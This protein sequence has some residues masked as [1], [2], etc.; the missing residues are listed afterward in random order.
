MLWYF[1]FLAISAAVIFL[2][3]LVWFLCPI[4]HLLDNFRHQKIMS[5]VQFIRI[6]WN[7][8]NSKSF[9][10]KVWPHHYTAHFNYCVLFVPPFHILTMK[11]K[12]NFPNI[13]CILG[14]EIYNIFVL[15][16]YFVCH[17]YK[18]IIFI[19]SRSRFFCTVKTLNLNF[20][21]RKSGK[22]TPKIT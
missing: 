3:K 8:L 11:V 18:L 7:H 9:S 10:R 5:C 20:C 21:A 13:I 4:S 12:K 1:L 2:I 14:I 19:H 15:L 17:S 6:I 16:N 22:I